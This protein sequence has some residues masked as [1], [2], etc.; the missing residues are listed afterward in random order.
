MVSSQK[1]LPTT[2]CS[3]TCRHVLFSRDAISPPPAVAQ[4]PAGP[5]VFF[6]TLCL[7]LL[8]DFQDVF[9]C[10]GTHCPL[11]RDL[12][13][14]W[15]CL[16]TPCP[17]PA[18]VQGPAGSVLSSWD[19]L[20][21]LLLL[22][23]QQDLYCCL[24]TP[25]LLLR[26]PQGLYCHFRTHGPLPSPDQGNSGLVVFSWNPLAP[27]CCFSVNRRTCGVASAHTGPCSGTCR[28]SSVVLGLIVTFQPLFRDPQDLRFH[29]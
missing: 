17:L 2:R 13:V 27:A 23:D 28:T 24:R 12:Q 7:Q 11:F 8:R 6:G 14:L 25:S 16:R 22:G 10:L 20:P 26:D 29:V 21:R 18:A 19:S 5:V 9:C 1:L 4:V 15:C 3:R